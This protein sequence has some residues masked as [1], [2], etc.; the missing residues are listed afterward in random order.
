M[1]WKYNQIL[2]DHTKQSATDALNTDSNKKAI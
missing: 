1:Q 2:L